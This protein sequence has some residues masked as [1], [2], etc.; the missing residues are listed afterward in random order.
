MYFAGYKYFVE[1]KAK[2]NLALD[3]KGLNANPLHVR[4]YE[5]EFYFTDEQKHSFKDFLKILQ[6]GT[7]LALGWQTCWLSLLHSPGCL[8][9]SY[10]S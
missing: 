9:S 7:S 5:H 6:P 1:I 4:Q 10:V 8:G 2:D 3:W